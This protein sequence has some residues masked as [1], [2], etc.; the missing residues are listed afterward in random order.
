MIKVYIL[1]MYKTGRGG[2]GGL[3]KEIN[4]II[5][6]PRTFFVVLNFLRRLCS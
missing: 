5:T 2:G 3:K 6:Y 4:I 1:L